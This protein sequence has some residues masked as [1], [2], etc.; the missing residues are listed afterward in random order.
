MN[1]CIG[2]GFWNIEYEACT[3]PSYDKWYACSI[4]SKK[5]ENIKEM[6]EYLEW[7]EKEEVT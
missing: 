4:E 3:C 1:E 2:C 7:L 5:P 6:K